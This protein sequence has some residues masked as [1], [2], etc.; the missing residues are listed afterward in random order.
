MFGSHD[1]YDVVTDMNKLYLKEVFE[2][3]EKQ[4]P[5]HFGLGLKELATAYS[6]DMEISG[7]IEDICRKY[8]EYLRKDWKRNIGITISAETAD[9]ASLPYPLKIVSPENTK[10]YEELKPSILTQ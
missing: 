4:N 3:L 10:K 5:R 6:R 7:L 1:A 9:N 2:K 8:G